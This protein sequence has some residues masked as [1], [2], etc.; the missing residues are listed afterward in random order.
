MCPIPN[1][2]SWSSPKK[3]NNSQFYV[4]V[5]IYYSG[6]LKDNPQV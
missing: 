4:M 5:Y 1:V 2:P 3:N 6:L